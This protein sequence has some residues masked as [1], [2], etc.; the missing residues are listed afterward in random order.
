M[1]SPGLVTRK[2]GAN[3]LGRRREGGVPVGTVFRSG[4]RCFLVLKPR[5]S[6]VG[7]LDLRAHCGHQLPEAVLSELAWGSFNWLVLDHL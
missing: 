4:V 2:R 3:A 1:V 7:A 6:R 5:A